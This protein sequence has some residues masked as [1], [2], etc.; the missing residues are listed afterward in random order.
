MTVVDIHCHTFNAD[1]LPVR[2]FVRYVGGSRHSLAKALA[3][4]LEK[5]TQSMSSGAEELVCLDRLIKRGPGLESLETDALE[6]ADDAADALLEQLEAEDPVLAQEAG[7]E[8]ARDPDPAATDGQ[9]GLRNLADELR[10]YL[11]WVALFGQ[12]RLAL[13]RSLIDLYP[14]VD[15]FTPLLVDFQGLEDQPKTTMTEQLELQERIS[16][17]G[18][19]GHFRA[20]VLPFVGFD[21][22][23]LGAVPMVK[24][25]ITD[26]GCI[27]VK[28]YPPV[29]FLPIGNVDDRPE[30]MSREAA[31]G[32]EE[33]LEN[34]YTWCQTEQV[35]ITA[36]SNPT[37]FAR[38][39]FLG[40]SNPQRWAK[41]L[42]RWPYL[43]LNLGHFGWNGEDWP[44]QISALMATYPF[45]HSDI[46]NH[47]L[48]DLSATINRLDGLFKDSGTKTARDRF[49]FGTD[50]FMVASHHRYSQFL[51]EVR[52]HY[53]ARFPDALE[54]F[55]GGN[56]LR[57]LGF[58]DP[59]N[60]NTQRVRSRYQLHSVDPPAWLATA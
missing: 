34:L 23:R 6:E 57:F 35:P 18:I 26:H 14:E 1:D 37:N 30:G 11:K 22:R 27:G 58:D 60:L 39:S 13:T 28:L 36:H 7:G 12:D 19:L 43:H 52:D 48:A 17:L 47:E 41:V 31:L 42:E 25:A 49:M 44:D 46:G 10:R 20:Q 51:T 3:W 2:G 50:W 4:S 40:N 16:R 8:A 32:A 55:M 9:E 29:G 24:R 33:A 53:G 59:K 56:A 38:Q 5:I 54:A 15:L 45:L 21:P